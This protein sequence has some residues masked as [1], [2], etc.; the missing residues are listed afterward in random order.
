MRRLL[1]EILKQ[2]RDGRPDLFEGGES[3]G[4]YDREHFEALL[5]DPACVVFT[6]HT[7]VVLRECK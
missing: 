4:K 7:T 3:A 2:H 6:A 5:D 1:N